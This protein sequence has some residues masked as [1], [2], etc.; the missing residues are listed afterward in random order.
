MKNSQSKTSFDIISDEMLNDIISTPDNEIIEE[1]KKSFSDFDQLIKRVQKTT[2]S[3][4][5]NSNK[6]YAKQLKEEMKTKNNSSRNQERK[7]YESHAK[8]QSII[9][10]ST[11][12]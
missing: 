4:V 10:P 1:A 9:K 6:K 12:S 5:I 2:E 7:N 3:A 11:I 8:I